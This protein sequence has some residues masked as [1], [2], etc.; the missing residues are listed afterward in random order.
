MTQNV[1]FIT[2]KKAGRVVGRRRFVNR[3]GELKRVVPKFRFFKMFDF[4]EAF[5]LRRRHGVVCERKGNGNDE[6]GG[7]QR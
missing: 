2:Q 7:E 4:G 5:R 3:F 6:R 1:E